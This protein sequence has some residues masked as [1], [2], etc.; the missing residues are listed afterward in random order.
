MGSYALK[1]APPGGGAR[2][3]VGAVV[4]AGARVVE[5]RAAA[6]W[7]EVGAAAAME[8]AMG[9]VRAG[10]EAEAGGEAGLVRVRVRVRVGARARARV[11]HWV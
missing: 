2:A 9:A 5:Q 1:L 10:E 3:W 11:W 6:G 8:T 7:G 4:G